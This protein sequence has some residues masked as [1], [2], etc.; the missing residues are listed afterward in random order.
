MSLEDLKRLVV[1]EM[2]DF[3]FDYEGKRVGVE[4]TVQNSIATY[5]MWWGDDEK[6]YSDFDELLSDGFFDG[7]SVIDLLEIVEIEFC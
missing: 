7:R 1:D 6:E 3:Y 4:Q 2:N 5:T